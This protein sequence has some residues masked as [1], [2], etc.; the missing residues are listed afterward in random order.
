MRGIPGSGKSSFTKLFSG[1][2]EVKIN[3]VDDLHKDKEGN[4]SWS[5]ENA[6]FFY[7]KNF[8]NFTEDC[9]K[10]YPVVICDCVNYKIEHF[11][12]YISTAKKFGYKSYV[13]TPDPISI[14]DS[15]NLN[16]HEVPRDRLEKFYKG[17]EPWPSSK[18]MRELIFK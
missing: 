17:W 14:S 11:D 15:E 4:F 7:E 13:V 9:K 12:C 2:R 10:G 3:S 18:K 5:S 16:L 6:D 8:K 1:N